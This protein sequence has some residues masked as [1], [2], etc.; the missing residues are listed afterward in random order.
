MELPHL[1]I[2][3]ALLLGEHEVLLV[4]LAREAVAELQGERVVVLLI[5][6]SLRHY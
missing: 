3:R 4:D 6:S 2:L 5:D 1:R